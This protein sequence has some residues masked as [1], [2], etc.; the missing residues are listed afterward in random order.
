MKIAILTSGGDAPGM[1]A[2]IRAIVK[3][4]IYNQIQTFGVRRGYKGLIEDDIIPLSVKDVDNIAEKGGTILKTA[5]SKEFKKEEVRRAA[6]EN[7][8]KRGIEG[9]IVIGGD[10]S[11]QGA[12]K[13]CDLGIKVMG[14]PGTID[15]DLAY[16]NYSIGFDTALNTVLDNINKIK[17]TGSSHEKGTIIEVM[18]RYC[19]DLALFSAIAGAGEIISTPE[20]KLSAEEIKAKLAANI[21]K[22]KDDNIVIITERMYDVEELKCYIEDNLDIG[23]RTTVLGFIQRG[24]KPTAL[25]RLLAGKMSIRAVELIKAGKS[26]RAIGIRDNHIIDIAFADIEKN[27]INKDEEYKSLE[28]LI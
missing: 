14:L 25:D 7:L 3:A 6:V 9:L 28:M 17:D 27:K 22:G 2:A 16:T 11:F 15:N 24:G 4:S 20:R 23:I 8:K 10:G 5:R 13:L 12:E 19:G 21:V 18:G 26:G 1:N